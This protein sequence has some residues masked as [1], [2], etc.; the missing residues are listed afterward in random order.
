MPSNGASRATYFAGFESKRSR[1]LL[2]MEMR[3]WIFE[4][5]LKELGDYGINNVGR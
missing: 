4:G 5:A 2:L 3:W 1:S